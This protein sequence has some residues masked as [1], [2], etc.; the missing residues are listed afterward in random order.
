MTFKYQYHDIYQMSQNYWWHLP[1]A[2]VAQ[3]IEHPHVK[4]KNWGSIPTR[5]KNQLRALDCAY[6]SLLPH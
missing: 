4:Q 5:R 3:W 1:K 6:L 2:L